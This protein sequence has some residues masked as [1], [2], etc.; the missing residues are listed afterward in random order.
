MLRQVSPRLLLVTLGMAVLVAGTV[1]AADTSWQE[2]VASRGATVMPFQ[3]QATKH[4]FTKTPMGGV[5]QVLVRDPA[6]STQISMIRM[7]LQMIAHQFSQGNFS[8]PMQIHGMNMPGLPVLQQAKPGSLQIRYQD[9]PAGGQ[10]DYVTQDA[11]LVTALHQ[12]FDAQV[13]DHGKDAEA[14]TMSH[15]G[16]QH[17]MMMPMTMP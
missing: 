12:W 15:D 1:Q 2:E 7:H 8:G 16:M 6:N 11:A 17:D 5:Q 13:S 9:L 14:G 4:V 3:L 10:I